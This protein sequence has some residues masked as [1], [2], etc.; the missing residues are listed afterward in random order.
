M[1]PPLTSLD[2]GVKATT[3]TI[4]AGTSEDDGI[5]IGT[6]RRAEMTAR[7]GADVAE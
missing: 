7:I 5:L 1:K 3:F 6:T 2:V 4:I